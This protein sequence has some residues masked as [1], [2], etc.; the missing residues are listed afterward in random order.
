[1]GCRVT[2]WDRKSNTGRRLAP[3]WGSVF[4]A[5][6]KRNDEEIIAARLQI[7]GGSFRYLP[8]TKELPA[9]LEEWF[10]FLEMN[11]NSTHRLRSRRFRHVRLMAIITTLLTRPLLTFSE[12]IPAWAKPFGSGQPPI[13]LVVCR[14]QAKWLA[15]S[16]S[17]AERRAGEGDGRGFAS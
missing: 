16:D 10:D 8:L 14:V 5:H 17:H 6:T 2:K 1:M 4:G 7:K 9:S 12:Y 3:A 11:S 13:W 15:S